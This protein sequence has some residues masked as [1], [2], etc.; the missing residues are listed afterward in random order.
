MPSSHFALLLTCKR[1]RELAIPYADLVTSIRLDTREYDDV[2]DEWQPI[3][4]AV[5]FEQVQRILRQYDRISFLTRQF[6][7]DYWVD[8][9]EFLQRRIVGS[10]TELNM[11]CP[12]VVETVRLKERGGGSAQSGKSKT[13]VERAGFCLQKLRKEQWPSGNCHCGECFGRWKVGG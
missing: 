10:C 7:D 8:E 11:D 9:L 5:E 1:V 2:H 13:G 12:K 4:I 6:M 3:D